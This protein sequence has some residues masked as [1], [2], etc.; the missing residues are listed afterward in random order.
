ML[1]NIRKNQGYVIAQ[2]LEST[3]NQA[4]EAEFSLGIGS[5]L[6]IRLKI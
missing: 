5:R 6:E 1:Q 4:Q 3:E 2:S